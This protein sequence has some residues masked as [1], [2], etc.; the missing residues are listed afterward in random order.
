M[1][2]VKTKIAR[3]HLNVS[4]QTLRKWADEGKIPYIRIGERGTRLYDIQGIKPPSPP[5][6][7]RKILYYRV[8]SSKQKEDLERQ[9][10]YLQE[11][12]PNHEVIK[13]ISSGIN[14]KR[15]GLKS[16]LDSSIQGLVEEVVVAHRDRLCRIAFEHFEWLFDHLGVNL[17]VDSNEILSTES[18]LANDLFEIIHVFSCRHYGQRRNYTSRGIKKDIHDEKTET[19]QHVCIENEKEGS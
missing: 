6:E 1:P 2:Y 18:E 13:E 14:F 10:L 5:P 11:K 3:E 8:S 4:N 15:K 16:I 19:T 17:V 7:K 12:Y 9:V